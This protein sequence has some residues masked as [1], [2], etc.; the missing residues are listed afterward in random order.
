MDDCI[1]AL[2]TSTFA[3]PSDKQF[4][5]HV[6]L[7]HATDDHSRNIFANHF[8]RLGSISR[9]DTVEILNSFKHQHA[10]LD[11]STLEDRSDSTIFNT[12]TVRRLRK[13]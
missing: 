7:Q 11:D 13:C 9:L 3:L 4:C 2:E 1:E 8:F 5:K 12:S 6:R 10:T